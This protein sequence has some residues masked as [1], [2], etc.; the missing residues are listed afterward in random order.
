MIL[1][2]LLLIAL[3]AANNSFS[4]N[5]FDVIAS[6]AIGDLNKDGITD[7]VLVT[8]DTTSETWPYNIEVFFTSENGDKVLVIGSDMAISPQY[9]NGRNTGSNGYGFDEVA[10]INGVLWIKVELMRG[11]FEHK[12]RYQNGDF[13]L[14]GYT[15]VSSDGLGTSRFVDYNL[16]TGRRIERTE[17]YTTDE[18]IE[19]SDK[20]FKLTSLPK[21]L[22]FKPFSNDL[23]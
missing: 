9:P 15:S 2:F 20:I 22:E 13:E 12:F 8:Q 21:L 3:L 10:I 16:S 7:L 19:S 14:I 6:T 4:Q 5:K 17:D 1:K 11:Y 23:Y 18:I